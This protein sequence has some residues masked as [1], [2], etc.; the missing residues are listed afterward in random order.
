MM[1]DTL[2]NYNKQVV[3]EESLEIEDFINRYHWK[4]N[5]TQTGL[6]YMI[7]KNGKGPY[8]RKG[9]LVSI[10]YNVRLLNG[11]LVYKSDS[12]APF[13]FEIGKRKVANGLEEGVMLMKPGDIAKLV[14][15]S[16][17]AFGL[18]GDM[19]KIPN[20]AILVYDVEI[21]YINKPN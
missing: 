13:K 12:L 2:L 7:Y 9:D 6:R 20:R 3:R 14:V 21:C 17:L 10:K 1:D 15:P 19:D 4:M 5:T 8:A 16:H 18:I 11:D